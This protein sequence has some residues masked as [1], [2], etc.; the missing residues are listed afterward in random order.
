MDIV[1]PDLELAL[2]HILL[3]EK[4]VQMQEARVAELQR[5]GLP[6]DNS[7]HLLETLRQ[8]LLLLK[9][10]IRLITDPASPNPTRKLASKAR[11]LW[12]R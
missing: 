12:F 1:Q 8:S 4:R 9:G 10:H 6:S 2:I 11:N 3:A 7:E 5:R